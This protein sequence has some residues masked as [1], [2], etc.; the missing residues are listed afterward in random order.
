M[1][2][3]VSILLPVAALWWLIRFDPV[4]LRSLRHKPSV[5]PPAL[6]WLQ[7]LPRRLMWLLVFSPLWLGIT[8]ADA[9][10]ALTGCG[11]AMVAGWLL[12]WPYQARR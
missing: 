11:A 6:S 7:H 3:F 4:R 1:M 10:L 5:L 9:Q 8:M 2:L 12:V